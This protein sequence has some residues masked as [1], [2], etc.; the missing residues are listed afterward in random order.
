[1]AFAEPIGAVE[2]SSPWTRGAPQNGLARLMSRINWRISSGTFGLPPRAR[3]PSPE[4]AKPGP[5]PADNRLRLD[6]HQGAQNVGDGSFKNSDDG[7]AEALGISESDL[8]SWLKRIAAR[9][10]SPSQAG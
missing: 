10:S 7:H 3:L 5:M 2:T 4:Q 8:L 9:P 1:R 6:D